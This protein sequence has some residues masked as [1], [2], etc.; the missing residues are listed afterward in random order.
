MNN[1]NELENI[2]ILKENKKTDIMDILFCASDEENALIREELENVECPEEYKNIMLDTMHTI[3]NHILEQGYFIIAD[4]KDVMSAFEKIKSLKGK[5]HFKYE[6]A[7]F[8]CEGEEG[9]IE[10]DDELEES[11][12]DETDSSPVV[13]SLE[14]NSNICNISQLLDSV[15]NS[16]SSKNAMSITYNGNLPEGYYKLAVWY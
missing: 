15:V 1:K 8:E 2:E 16:Y 3:I 14:I 6:E 9:D 13:V 7:Y 11:Q 4:Y 10:V 5:I 12:E